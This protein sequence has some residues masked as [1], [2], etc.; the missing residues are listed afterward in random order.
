MSEPPPLATLKTYAPRDPIPNPESRRS[1]SSR[2]HGSD[3]GHGRRGRT[4]PLVLSPETAKRL[5]AKLRD[6]D[7]A[8]AAKP[9]QKQMLARRAKLPA[10]DFRDRIIRTIRDNPVTVISGETGC[11]KTTQVPQ[12]VLEDLIRSSLGAG[13]NMVCTQPRRLSAMAVASRV[14]VERGESVGGT[15]GYSI[16]LETKQSSQ[17]RLLFCTTGILLQR[18]QNNPDLDGVS[19]IFVDEVSPSH[20]SISKCT[21]LELIDKTW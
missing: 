14:A 9:A 21:R 7:R 16:R 4:K 13:C 19:H 3:G 18:L 11:G 8:S 12:F 17:T 6:Q 2:K 10:A 1:S 5:S 15:V 20:R